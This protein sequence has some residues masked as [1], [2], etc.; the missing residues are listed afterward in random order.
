MPGA[1]L[2]STHDP[3]VMPPLL[4]DWSVVHTRREHPYGD[5]RF[6]HSIAVGCI[7]ICRAVSTS[8]QRRCRADGARLSW[9]CRCSSSLRCRYCP[10]ACRYPCFC[11][12]CHRSDTCAH[13]QLAAP[14]APA[15]AAMRVPSVC[16]DLVAWCLL[17]AAEDGCAACMTPL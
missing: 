1:L 15:S 7:G 10:S 14:A 13:K 2:G 5:S 12:D 17:G 3:P 16:H 8:T 9:W 6:Q 4:C 11:G